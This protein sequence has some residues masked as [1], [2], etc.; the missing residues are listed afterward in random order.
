M[1]ILFVSGFSSNTRARELAHEFERFGPL[2]RCDVP[3]PRN[4]HSRAVPYA[5]VEFRDG[6][7]AEN[8]Y[9]DMHG[10]NFDGHRLSIQWAR[11]PPS[12]GWRVADGS[13]PP[14]RSDRDSRARSRSPRRRSPERRRDR[15]AEPRD[16]RRHSSR[17]R[18]RDEAR[19]PPPPPYA[20]P[21]AAGDDHES[22]RRDTKEYKDSKDSEGDRR[23]SIRDRRGGSRDRRDRDDDDREARFRREDAGATLE[24]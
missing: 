11:K 9:H 5:F 1:R 23:G 22:D 16:R 21:M 14:P 6:R 2:V 19:T 12:A 15:D 13:A 10:R 18:D 17:G 8:A 7:D 3:A 4:S 20:T 24:D